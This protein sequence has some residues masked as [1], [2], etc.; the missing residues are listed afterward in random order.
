RAGGVDVAHVD[1]RDARHPA[2]G[3]HLSPAPHRVVQAV[4]GPLRVR[5]VAARYVLSLHRPARD[6]HRLRRVADIVD[7]QNVA[8]EALHFSRDI[9]VVLIHIETMHTLAVGFYEAQE[10]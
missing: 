2:A 7:D 9:G 1:D 6:L 3:I 10:L 5:L 8:D 4:L